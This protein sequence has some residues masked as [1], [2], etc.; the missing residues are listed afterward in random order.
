M[1]ASSTAFFAASTAI[2]D[3]FSLKEQM[4]VY[5]QSSRPAALGAALANDANQ[6]DA[7][8][9]DI[10]ARINLLRDIYLPADFDTF[11]AAYRAALK[12]K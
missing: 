1:P 9:N 2:V 3:G 12:K 5:V 10:N 6:P 4:N 8:T 7:D 11:E